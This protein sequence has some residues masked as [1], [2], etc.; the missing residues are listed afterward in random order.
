MATVKPG[1]R[2]RVLALV[3]GIADRIARTIDTD[4]KVK[5]YASAKEGGAGELRRLLASIKRGGI[6]EVWVLVRWIGH[7]E[8]KA[9]D[10][11][12]R[13]RGIH[14]ER[15]GGLAQARKRRR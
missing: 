9:I 15:L 10:R 5:R 2:R 13:K 3:G 6:D 4:A 11:E 8:S 1:K 7:S 14:V 12:C